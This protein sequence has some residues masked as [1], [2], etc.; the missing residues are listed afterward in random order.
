MTVIVRP[1]GSFGE[2][3]AVPATHRGVRERGRTVFAAFRPV[4]AVYLSAQRC[5]PVLLGGVEDPYVPDGIPFA[6]K[7]ACPGRKIGV[8][9]RAD[10][11]MAVSFHD[12][13]RHPTP[14]LQHARRRTWRGERQY[15]VTLEPIWSIGLNQRRIVLIVR[16]ALSREPKR[17]ASW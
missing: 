5:Y 10:D 12:R 9:R 8:V 15:R 11:D 6:A 17:R 2:L 7:A 14:C 16:R 3:V 1:G 4:R 13:E